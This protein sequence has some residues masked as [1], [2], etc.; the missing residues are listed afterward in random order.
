MMQSLCRFWKERLKLHTHLLLCQPM[1]SIP[2]RSYRKQNV[3]KILPRLPLL[4]GG[5]KGFKFLIRNL[6]SAILNLKF[7]LSPLPSIGH[8][9]YQRKP[10]KHPQAKKGEGNP[11]ARNGVRTQMKDHCN[12]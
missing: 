3:Y 6:Q 5:M 7:V 8:H 9:E 2:W 10:K 11:K 4:R 1:K 12:Q